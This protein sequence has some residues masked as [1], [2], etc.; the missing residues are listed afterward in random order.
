MRPALLVLLAAVPLGAQIVEGHVINAAT[1]ADV[2]G[3]SIIIRHVAENPEGLYRSTTDAQGR[4]RIDSLSP[5]TYAAFYRA[6]GYWTDPDLQDPDRQPRFQVTADGRTVTLEY[7]LQP[8]PKI[9]GHVLDAAGK[10][11][12]KARIWVLGNRSGC[13][14]L[15]CYPVLKQTETG[16]KGEY[17][18]SDADDPESTWLISADAP[19]S[20]D[21]PPSADGRRLGWTQTFYPS[22]TDVQLAGKV[23]ARPGTEQWNLDIKLAAVPVH[24]VRG[25]VVDTR[26]EPLANATVT[27]YNGLGPSFERTTKSDGVFEFESVPDAEW[28]VWTKQDQGTIKAW[29]GESLQVKG[30]DAEKIELRPVPPVDFH[31]KV[32]WDAPEGVPVPANP[33]NVV[34]VYNAAGFGQDRTVPAFPIGHPDE[35]GNFTIQ[36][37]PGPYHLFV[38][39]SPPG[40]FYLDS[41]RLANFDALV[42]DAVP[43]LSGDQPLVVTY[44]YGG[45]TVRGAVETCGGGRVLLIPADPALRRPGLVREAACGPNGQFEFTAVRPGEY[46]GFAASGDQSPQIDTLLSRSPKI[47]VRNNEHTTAEI[48]LWR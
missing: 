14:D 28:R 11:V 33:P 43:I 12:P 7:K 27:L 18:I 3:V 21:A 15:P 37:Y 45:G 5:G 10:P 22:A 31:G 4:F 24:S 47:T 13:N 17:L 16:E 48:R 42:S 46:Y 23:V 41:M 32:I 40:P 9:A 25:R 6:R 34:F 19:P 38:L 30:R 44:K 26:G 35:K 8:L 29:A 1:G 2:A 36:I 20:F 39:D